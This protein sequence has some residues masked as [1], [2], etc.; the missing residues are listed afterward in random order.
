MEITK[1]DSKMLK[2]VAVLGLL[3]LH[4]FCRKA[5]LPYAPLLWL[6]NTPLVYY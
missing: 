2:G 3:M 4:L 1:Q 5:N 6:G